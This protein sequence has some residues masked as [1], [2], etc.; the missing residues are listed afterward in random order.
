MIHIN[1][2]L[3]NTQ[4][5]YSEIL[6]VDN[7]YWIDITKTFVYFPK[8]I[9]QII[10]KRLISDFKIDTNIRYKTHGIQI[11]TSKENSTLNEIEDFCIDIYACEDEYY[12]V[13]IVDTR[14]IGRQWSSYYKC[15]GDFGL[16]KFLEDFDII[17]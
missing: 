8:S 12:F 14:I 10:E 7:Y 3:E 16:I 11:I 15:D 6:N 17:K 9:F 4:Y 13:E 5:P 1:R 2:F